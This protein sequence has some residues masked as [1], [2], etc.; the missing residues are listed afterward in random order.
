LPARTL[1]LI[2]ALWLFFSA[3]AWPRTA[4]TFTNAWIVGL[5]GAIFA[6]AGMTKEKA[7]FA[8]TA[9]SAWLLASA[10]VLAHRSPVARWNDVVVAVGMLA[11]S[12]VPG[13][14]QPRAHH[15]RAHA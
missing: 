3:F 9:L 13:S 15:R 2:L 12:L 11:L 8:N 5:L 1:N 4:P 6:V 14:L 7:R 10:F